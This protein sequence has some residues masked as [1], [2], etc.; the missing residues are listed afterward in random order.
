[1]YWK[2]GLSANCELLSNYQTCAKIQVYSHII[3][4]KQAIMSLKVLL[5]NNVKRHLVF[6]VCIA[7]IYERNKSEESHFKYE[8]WTLL[9]KMCLWNFSM[10]CETVKMNVRR[11]DFIFIEV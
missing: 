6:W 10:H 3:T 1:M 8:W 11:A 2:D 5:Q 9:K 7:K 4:K